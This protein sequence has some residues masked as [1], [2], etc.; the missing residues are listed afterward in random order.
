MYQ[1]TKTERS[2]WGGKERRLVEGDKDPLRRGV[3]TEKSRSWMVVTY[4]QRYRVR[5]LDLT[6]SIP[7]LNQRDPFVDKRPG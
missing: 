4:R 6:D 2:L 1:D 7:I 3:C 5:S